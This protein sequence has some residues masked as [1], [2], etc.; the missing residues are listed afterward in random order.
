MT[1]V[2][3]VDDSAFMRMAIKNIL[4]DKDYEIFEAEDGALAVEKFIECAPDIIT[5]DIT[6]PQYNGI[7]ALKQIRTID[8]NAKVV[9]ISAMGQEM[10]VKQALV[11]GA[12]AFIVKPFKHEQVLQ[13]LA[14]VAST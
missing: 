3:V 4:A 2:L 13:T 11:H 9:M 5:M 6:M 10:M 7:D 12:T 14:K 1:K 8:G